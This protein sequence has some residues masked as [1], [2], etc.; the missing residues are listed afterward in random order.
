MNPCFGAEVLSKST[1]NYDRGEKFVAYR[2]IPKLQEYLLIDQYKIHVEPHVKTAVNQ[3]LFSEYDDPTVILSLSTLE[4]Q[5]QIAN[6][7]EDIEF[8]EA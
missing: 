1:Q 3:W 8:T 6:L 2:T 5:F 7:Y 4:C